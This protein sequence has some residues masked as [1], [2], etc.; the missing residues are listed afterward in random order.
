MARL[1]AKGRLQLPIRCSGLKHFI[2]QPLIHQR[3][4]KGK[5]SRTLY[6]LLKDYIVFKYSSPSA[7]GT[8]KSETRMRNFTEEIF[9]SSLNCYIVGNTHQG[10]RFLL[11]CVG[12][13][14]NCHKVMN[15]IT[16][17]QSFLSSPILM[18]VVLKTLREVEKGLRISKPDVHLKTSK[19]QRLWNQFQYLR[20]R[21]RRKKFFLSFPD[22]QSID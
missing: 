8:L 15:F 18:G 12:V 6:N 14:K 21:V 9:H 10:C 17:D 2:H 20:R 1:Q 11:G 3:L 22:D 13:T 4:K 5:M 16:K 19:W 7:S